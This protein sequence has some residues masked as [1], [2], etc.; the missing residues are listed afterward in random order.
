MS[1]SSK[2]NIEVGS[3]ISTLVSRTKRRRVARPAPAVPVMDVPEASG[4]CCSER[5]RRF[6]YFLHVSVH[7]H[8]APF[9]PQDARGIDQERAAFDAHVLAP[10]QGL[11][12]D[13]AKQPTSLL[14]GVG[15]QWVGQL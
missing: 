11:F 3:C 4:G 1:C 7:F 9:A 14:V 8:L 10:V 13:H 2:R 5:L 15:Q 12:L 6:K